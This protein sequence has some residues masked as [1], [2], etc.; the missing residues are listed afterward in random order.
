VQENRRFC[1]NCWRSETLCYCA[2]VRAISTR[3]NWVI[4][5]HPRE[6]KRT[7]GTARIAHLGLQGSRIVCGRGFDDDPLVRSLLDDSSRRCVVLYPGRD[8]L[9]LT[10]L[11]F[12]ERLDRLQDV[13]VFLIDGTWGTARTLLRN[14]PRVAA[15]PRISFSDQSKSEYGFRKQ[16]NAQCISTLEAIC[17]LIS[18]TEPELDCRPLMEIFRKMVKE[19]LSYTETPQP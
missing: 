19:Q 5:Q 18:L 9:D 15:L 6:R 12:S 16:P 11:S 13:T 1:W 14:S 2:D 4:L 10:P 7:I 17:H 3:L 8:S